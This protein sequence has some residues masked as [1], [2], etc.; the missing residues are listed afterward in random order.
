MVF[1]RLMNENTKGTM[2]RNFMVE[3]LWN[4]VEFRSKKLAQVSFKII[5]YKVIC[6]VFIIFILISEVHRS[7]QERK[8]GRYIYS[9]F[10]Y[11]LILKYTHVLTFTSLISIDIS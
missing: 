1:V 7:V 11:L 6:I 10:F 2:I 4:D 8:I 3:A 5:N 9:I